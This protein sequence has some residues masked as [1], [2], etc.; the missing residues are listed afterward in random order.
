MNIHFLTETQYSHIHAY[1]HK[2]TNIYS[3]HKYLNTQT[4]CCQSIVFKSLKL[5][6]YLRNKNWLQS[7]SN[8]HLAKIFSY[9]S[10]SRRYPTQS[11]MDADYANDIM[12]LVNTPTQAEALLHSLERAVSDIGLHMNTDKKELMCINQ[13]S[14]IST[15]NAVLYKKLFQCIPI[16]ESY[17]SAFLKP[18]P[19]DS[20]CK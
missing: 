18:F 13:R 9:N 19:L 11:I 8:L 6:Y 4:I 12:L 15:L 14:D 5:Q 20:L 7:T 3:T 2:H 1:T 16:T 10:R 17:I